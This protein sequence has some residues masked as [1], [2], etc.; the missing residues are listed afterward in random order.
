MLVAVLFVIIAFVVL[1]ALVK[2]AF[3]L[4]MLAIVLGLGVGGYLLAEKLV[5]K[6][7]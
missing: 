5:G 7:R 2:V 1:I 4:I 3:S 6:G